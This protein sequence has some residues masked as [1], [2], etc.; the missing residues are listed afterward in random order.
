MAIIYNEFEN[1]RL[2]LYVVTWCARSNFPD[3]QTP[4][5]KINWIV[6]SSICL[7]TAKTY[8]HAIVSAVEKGVHNAF[9]P[10][11]D[12]AQ[13]EFA[14]YVVPFELYR[15]YDPKNKKAEEFSYKGVT[16]KVVS[17]W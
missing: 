1:K 12:D 7:V 2:N 13:H 10:F 4:L 8:K 6:D 5:S 17:F 16:Y 9:S 11:K 15:R 3:Q 14:F